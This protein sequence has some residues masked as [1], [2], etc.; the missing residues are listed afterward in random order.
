M[1]KI[2]NKVVGD[3]G[4]DRAVEYLKN[5][6]YR[7]VK[8]NFKNKLGEIDVIA[9]DKDILVFVEVKTRSSDMFGLPREAV[10]L[11][12]QRKIRLVATSYIKAYKLFD[13]ICRFDVVEVLPDSI[14]I[15]KDCF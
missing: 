5:N 9:Y 14:E 7:I 4:E 10:N 1:S 3:S 13:K 11:Q 2:F 15:L 12:K 8:R 6:G